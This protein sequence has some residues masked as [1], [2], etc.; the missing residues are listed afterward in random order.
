MYRNDEQNWDQRK[1]AGDHSIPRARMSG[2]LADRL[3]HSTCNG[4]RGDGKRDHL[5]PVLTGSH[6]GQWRTASL[7]MVS[8]E[9][10]LMAWP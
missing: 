3:L 8:T 4:Q 1:L 6:P 2:T 7:L 10:R 9:P 5:R